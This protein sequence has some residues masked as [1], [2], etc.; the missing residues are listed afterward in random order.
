MVD[1]FRALDCQLLAEE[2]PAR[3]GEHFGGWILR[4]IEENGLGKGHLVG[5]CEDC[6]AADDGQYAGIAGE[7]GRHCCGQTD[8]IRMSKSEE[9]SRRKKLE[10]TCRMVTSYTLSNHLALTPQDAKDV[11]DERYCRKSEAVC[12]SVESAKET[13]RDMNIARKVLCGEE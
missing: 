7:N 9:T 10:F 2:H 3:H 8:V 4:G 1:L 11:V 6:R 13:C 12:D 5:E